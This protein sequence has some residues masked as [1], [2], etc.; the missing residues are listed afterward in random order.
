MRYI[1]AFPTVIFPEGLPQKGSSALNAIYFPVFES[2]H[3]ILNEFQ[4][5]NSISK[6]WSQK[7][8]VFHKGHTSLSGDIDF[9]SYNVTSH[10]YNMTKPDK[11]DECLDCTRVH[12]DFSVYGEALVN[13]ISTLIT[14]RIIN[15]ST[16]A[17]LF[18]EMTFGQLIE[19]LNSAWRI[20]E[21]VSGDTPSSG[22]EKWVHTI[23]K[24]FE[25]LERLGLSIP[26]SKPAPKKRGPKPKKGSLK[27]EQ[28]EDTN[29]EPTALQVVKQNDSEGAVLQEKEASETK[30]PVGR[31]RKNPPPEPTKPKRPV[32]RPRTRPLPDPE[33]PKRPVGR[34]RIRP[35]P[36][37]NAPK[38]PVGRPKKSL[39]AEEIT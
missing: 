33:A 28:K 4:A 35:L 1:K 11:L 5:S 39:N 23:P 3:T 2:P 7:S 37:P 19:D 30:R 14:C 17:R 18:D 20:K 12:G 38:R 24:V 6:N 9:N 34:P 36:D 13:F 21:T 25:I 10:I 32:G 26:V 15:L 29:K 27:A 22:D 31:P 16:K 8:A